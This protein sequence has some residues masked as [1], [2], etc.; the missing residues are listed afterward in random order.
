M[1]AALAWG[2]AQGLYGAALETQD[3][4]LKACRFY[5]KSGFELGSV[6]TVSYTHLDAYTRQL[7]SSPLL[8]KSV[9]N[10]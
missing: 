6:D 2:R 8:R 3:W 10:S 9:D 5:I 1:D 4:N 7:P